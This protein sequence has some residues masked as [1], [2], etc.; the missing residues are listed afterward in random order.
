MNPTRVMQFTFDLLW[1]MAFMYC[2]YLCVSLLLL[3]ASLQNKQQPAVTSSAAVAMHLCPIYVLF[4]PDISNGYQIR[5][6]CV[7]RPFLAKISKFEVLALLASPSVH[8]KPTTNKNSS[9]HHHHYYLLQI[10]PRIFSLGKPSTKRQCALSIT[11]VNG[12]TITD[13]LQ[14]QG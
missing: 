6:S 13:T 4:C 12:D 9:S 11:V 14:Q 2:F 3:T 5:F 1:A 10:L 7:L 8:K